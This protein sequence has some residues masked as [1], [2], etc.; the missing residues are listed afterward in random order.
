MAW[1]MTSRLAEA[2]AIIEELFVQPRTARQPTLTMTGDPPFAMIASIRDAPTSRSQT[3]R[4]I[5]YADHERQPIK[6]NGGAVVWQCRRAGGARRE[7]MDGRT[8]GGV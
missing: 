1:A 4:C 3:C 6:V 8:A 7:N 5:C 2:K